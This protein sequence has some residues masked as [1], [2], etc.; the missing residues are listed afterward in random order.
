MI[1]SSTPVWISIKEL[2]WV[3]TL[4]TVMLFM[5]R[6]KFRFVISLIN[7]LSLIFPLWMLLN[8]LFRI[9]TGRLNKCSRFN[10]LAPCTNS[11]SLNTMFENTIAYSSDVASEVSEITSMVVLMFQFEIIKFWIYSALVALKLPDND[12]IFRTPVVE[13]LTVTCC[14]AVGN[15]ADRSIAVI[16][17]MKLLL[18][19]EVYEL[20][21]VKIKKLAWSIVASLILIIDPSVSVVRLSAVNWVIFIWPYPP[22]KYIPGLDSKL[23]LVR[24]TLDKVTEVPIPVSLIT[25]TVKLI[26]VIL[27][28][29]VFLIVMKKHELIWSMFSPFMMLEWKW[30]LSIVTLSDA[31][32]SNHLAA[33]WELVNVN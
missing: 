30:M 11:K 20:M 14:I 31:A 24:D 25:T 29:I 16:F 18:L 21:L 19:L 4:L 33:I 17:I 7:G 9:W 2:N 8:S 26:W 6:F 5:T 13:L 28:N 1:E 12:S 3:L 27:S 22:L 15:S 10:K 23:K 32:I